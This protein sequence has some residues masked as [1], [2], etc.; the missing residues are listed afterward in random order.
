MRDD[1]EAKASITDEGTQGFP[2]VMADHEVGD[3]ILIG[4]LAIDDHELCAAILC[5]QGKTGGR[6]H[7]QRRA[8]RQ[9]QVAMLRELEALADGA[10]DLS[11]GRQR[12]T[13]VRE[14]VP[15][16]RDPS[17]ASYGR[18]GRRAS[19]H[20]QRRRAASIG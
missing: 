13:E 8:D 14:R 16:D 12:S 7:H 1:L 2:D 3:I 19:P 18:S 5:H 20:R 10:G 17:A 6:P 4:R 15:R 11:S 9:K